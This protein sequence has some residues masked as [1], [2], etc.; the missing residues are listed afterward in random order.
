MSLARVAGP[1]RR[2]QVKQSHTR[3]VS[4]LDCQVPETPV[5]L[6]VCLCGSGVPVPGDLVWP[7]LSARGCTEKAE[8]AGGLRSA[9]FRQ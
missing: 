1:C 4:E 3:I 9:P 8:T 7:G 5:R 2:S 6:D